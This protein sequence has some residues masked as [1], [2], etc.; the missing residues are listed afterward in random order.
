M[1][2]HSTFDVMAEPAY[3][4]FDCADG[5]RLS[6]SIAH[7]DKFWMSLCDLLG[8]E[9]CRLL[10][11]A[12]RIAKSLNLRRRIASALL[13]RSRDEWGQAL[14]RA[15]IPWGPVNAIDDVLSDPHLRARGLFV[16]VGSGRQPLRAVAHPLVF[17]GERPLAE[18]GAP[19]LG[20]AN[21]TY[22]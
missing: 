16:S 7:E 19:L 12:E 6:L 14:D 10:T 9:D 1:N 21:N 22:L 18:G 15:G 13:R 3:G 8:I 5:A 17:D 11:R 4:V 20:E 2:G